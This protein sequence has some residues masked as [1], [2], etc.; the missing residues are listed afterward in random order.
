M[1]YVALQVKTSYSMLSSLNRIDKLVKKASDL[2]YTT[3]AITDTN[4][5]FGVMEFYL[6]C[7]KYNIKPIIVL[8]ISNNDIDILLYAKN[9]NGYK[10]LI[11]LSTII[12]ERDITIED[13][14]NYKDNLIMIMPYNKF[15][16]NIYELYSNK[17]IGYSNIEEKNHRCQNTY[18]QRT[19]KAKRER[20]RGSKKRLLLFSG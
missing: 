1:T 8:E 12:S 20:H 6:E 10:N 18:H 4:N 3:L 5:M 19:K 7:Q 17:Y 11:K 15:N 13:L 16:P 9:N 2:G 14:N